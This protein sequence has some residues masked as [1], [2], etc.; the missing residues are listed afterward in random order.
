MIVGILMKTSNIEVTYLGGYGSDLTV[1][2]AARVSFNKASKWENDIDLHVSLGWSKGILSERDGK[3]INY[4][5]KHKHFSPFN[6]A[7]LSFRVKAPIF[8][9]RQLVKHKFMPINEVSRRYVT[10]DPEFYIPQRWRMA[11]ENVKQGSSDTAIQIDALYREQHGTRPDQSITNRKLTNW[12]NRAKRDGRVFDLEHDDI[13]WTTHCP[14]LG[15]ELDYDVT[16]QGNSQDNSPSLDRIDNSK[17]YVKGNVQV[18]SKLANTMKSSA[19]PEMI[20]KFVLAM[21]PR[22]GIFFKGANTVEE[23][24]QSQ[25]ELYRKAIKE[26]MCAEQ[27][28]MFLPQSTMTEWI[29]SGTLGAFLDML[30]LRLDPH[31]QYES[32]IVAQQIAE[33]VKELFPVSFNARIPL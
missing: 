15:I 27:A 28:R 20:Q 24:Y 11:A 6:H 33:K 21:A 25:L 23:Y 5:A 18:I 32:R 16:G 14:I 9:A 10:E 31:T 22:Y 12:R 4:L 3:L 1:V 7:F 17:D 19:S 30:V 2:N 13:P 8:V 29:W 26:G